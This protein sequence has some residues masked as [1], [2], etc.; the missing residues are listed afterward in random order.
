MAAV[1]GDGGD[2]PGEGVEG[3]GR[4][5]SRGGDGA[6]AAL[7]RGTPPDNTNMKSLVSVV[8]LI[9]QQTG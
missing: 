2:R 7:H 6:V 4:G 1:V 5:G 9:N 3:G 8:N